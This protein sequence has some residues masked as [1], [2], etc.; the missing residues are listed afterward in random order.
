MNHK[1]VWLMFGMFFENNDR[2]IPM[3]VQ[4]VIFKVIYS[5]ELKSYFQSSVKDFSLAAYC[6]SFVLHCLANLKPFTFAR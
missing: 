6:I 1:E 3:N 2:Q 5:Y 4:G